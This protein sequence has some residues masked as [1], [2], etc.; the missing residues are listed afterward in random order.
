[1]TGGSVNYDSGFTVAAALRGVSYSSGTDLI[2]AQSGRNIGIA[3]S[4]AQIQITESGVGTLAWAYA[5]PTN[6]SILILWRRTASGVWLKGSYNIASA[7][8]SSNAIVAYEVQAVAFGSGIS[9]ASSSNIRLSDVITWKTALNNPQLAQIVQWSR[10]NR[11]IETIDTG[12][13]VIAEGDSIVAGLS[14]TTNWSYLVCTALGWIIN[15]TA[16]P[17]SHVSDVVSRLVTDYTYADPFKKRNIWILNIGVNDLIYPPTDASGVFA[18]WEQLALNIISNGWTLVPATILPGNYLGS[19]DISNQRQFLNDNIRA[20]AIRRGL[21]L[22]DWDV[23]CPV[24]GTE[25]AEFNLTNFNSDNLHPTVAG[26]S[27]LAAA[28][29]QTA[30]STW[31]P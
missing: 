3:N 1:M 27:L 21:N 12:T 5:V 31:Y 14:P 29:A 2:W 22:L 15:N 4:G 28:A 11:G 19:N 18:A 20:F 9:G 7:A 13:N 8:N 23:I 16:V 30:L 25:G 10:V 24:M 17:G 26:H 6:R